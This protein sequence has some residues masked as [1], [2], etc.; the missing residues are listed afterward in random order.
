MIDQILL[1]QSDYIEIDVYYNG[2]LT[3]VDEIKIKT[4][5]DPDGTTL[6][7]NIDVE[8]GATPGRYQYLVPNNFTTKLGVYRAE[9]EF[10]VN[11]IVFKHLQLF[12]VVNLITEGYIT[13]EEVKQKTIFEKIE[14][15][16]LSEAT[17]QKYIDRTTAIIDSYVG[18]SLSY[19]HYTETNR[20]IIDKIN[21]GLQIRLKHRPVV[22]VTSIDVKVTPSSERALNV[23]RFRI[24]EDTGIIETFN[25]N[26]SSLV[27]C[28]GDLHTTPIIPHATISYTAGYITFPD[29][30][31]FAA[32]LITEDLLKESYGGQTQEIASFAIDDYKETYRRKIDEYAKRSVGGSDWNTIK[33]ILN[34][35]RQSSES[36]GIVGILG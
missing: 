20:C 35:Y 25:L 32:F 33:K 29:D 10:T 24:K 12:Q 21:N 30:L 2:A 4:L 28:K 26:S 34:K 16:N 5:M 9:W 27:V 36:P 7:T 17:I 19:T 23:D 22:S 1:N 14:E 13:P 31:R 6:G 18:G 11:N 3:S 15:E 8:E